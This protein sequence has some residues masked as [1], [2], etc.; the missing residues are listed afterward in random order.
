MSIFGIFVRSRQERKHML[1][2]DKYGI[3][4]TPMI[5]LP[6]F[7]DNRILIKLESKNFLGSV[8]ARS[9]Y[10]MVKNLPLA[11][12]GKVIV[13]STSGNLGFALGFFCNETG[14]K[15]LALIDPTVAESKRRR[16]EKAGITYRMVG[17][18]NGYDYRSS[19]I[20]TAQRLAEG[21]EFYWVNQYDNPSNVEAHQ[22]TT[23]FEIWEG[24]YGSVTH[25]VCAMGSCGTICGVG[26]YLHQRNPR[27][28]I[29][30]VEPYGSTIFGTEKA[31]YLNAGAGLV[32]KPGNLLRHADSVDEAYVVPDTDSIKAAKELKQD[33]HISAG[34]TTGM[35]F[36][37]AM[38]LASRLR[39][40]CI[41]VISPDGG[42]SY[43][44]YL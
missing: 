29:V 12:E 34:I 36:Y 31:D 24:T 9:G 35:A 2:M 15:F 27:I 3:G 13:E 39:K 42:E 5:E 25:V 40:A 26:T 11:S 38:K 30:G 14:R 18:E 20:L 10:F 41:V 1:S 19:R 33:F 22:M 17:K 23:A 28:T 6:A 21:G 37:Q 44:A 7:R 8:K 32:G 4:N 16:M 43:D